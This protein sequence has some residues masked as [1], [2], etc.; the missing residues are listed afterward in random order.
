MAWVW[1]GLVLRPPWKAGKKFE[2]KPKSGIPPPHTRIVLYPA[3]AAEA[4]RY[5]NIPAVYRPSIVSLNEIVAAI[6][7]SIQHARERSTAHPSAGVGLAC[8]WDMHAWV[9]RVAGTCAR[10]IPKWC[11]NCQNGVEIAAHRNKVRAAC[12]DRGAIH[13]KH[14]RVVSLAF[15][16]HGRCHGGGVRVVDGDHCRKPEAWSAPQLP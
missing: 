6:N 10:N 15:F 5:R 9:R 11:R 7:I 3:C 13:P 2:L 16:S 12:H 14:H 8:C 4:T 1:G